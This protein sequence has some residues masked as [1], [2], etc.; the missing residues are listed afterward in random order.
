MTIPATE[1]QESS[2]RC[3]CCG[4]TYSDDE[5][6]HLG[7]R[8]EAA[9]CFGCARFLNQR[10]RRAQDEHSTTIVARMRGMVDQGRDFVVEHGWHRLPVLGSTLRWLGDHLPESSPIAGYCPRCPS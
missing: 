10:A 9:V 5:L 4:Q 7:S 2:S 8:P 6:V 1:T 3:W